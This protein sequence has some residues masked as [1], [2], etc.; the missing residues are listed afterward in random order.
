MRRV[1]TG[2]CAA[3]A[4]WLLWRLTA[5]G[6]PPGEAMAAVLGWGL[7]LIP[8]HVTLRAPDHRKGRRVVRRPAECYER[9]TAERRTDGREGRVRGTGRWGRDG[10]SG[11]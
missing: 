10:G 5:P 1:L 7:G 6:A 8:V 2:A 9:E 11:R 3:A 4:A